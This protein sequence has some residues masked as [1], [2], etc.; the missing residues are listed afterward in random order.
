MKLNEKKQAD[1]IFLNPRLAKA[2]VLD[3]T[4]ISLYDFDPSLDKIIYKSLKISHNLIM[5]LPPNIN[6]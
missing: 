2:D 5:L 3:C 6:I 4:N 1:V